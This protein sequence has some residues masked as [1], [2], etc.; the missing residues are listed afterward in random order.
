MGEMLYTFNT[1]FVAF[2]NK[3]GECLY[4]LKVMCM[5]WITRSIVLLYCS[6]VLEQG[7][8]H[9]HHQFRCFQG[10][11]WLVS[12]LINSNVTIYSGTENDLFTVLLCSA[13][14]RCCAP[15]S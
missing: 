1:D 5:E 9:L 7:A 2:K 12:I 3:S 15:S 13:L 11:E 10:R 6:V 8:L 4:S 14:A